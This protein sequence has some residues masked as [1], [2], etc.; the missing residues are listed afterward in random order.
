MTQRVVVEGPHHLSRS[1]LA[2]QGLFSCPPLPRPHSLG[3]GISQALHSWLEA[4]P[5]TLGSRSFQLLALSCCSSRNLRVTSSIESCRR[6]QKPARSWKVGTGNAVGSCSGRSQ[7][8]GSQSERPE[9]QPGPEKA[10]PHPHCPVQSGRVEWGPGG[11]ETR[12]SP[13]LSI[14]GTNTCAHFQAATRSGHLPGTHTWW[15]LCP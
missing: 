13:D 10:P 6:S 4:T 1:A 5:P 8:G 7:R 3:K 15:A 14:M 2:T 12:K 9:P 11:R